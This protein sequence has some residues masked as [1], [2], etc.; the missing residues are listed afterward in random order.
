MNLFP[1]DCKSAVSRY[2]TEEVYEQLK[3]LKTKRGVTLL[4]IINSGVVNLDSSNGVYLGD[5]E[6]YTLF[7]PLINPIIEEYQTPYKVTDTHPADFDPEHLVAPNPDPEGEFILSTRVRVARNLHGYGLTP[8]LTKEERVEIERRVV[9][10][11][12]SLGGELAGHYYPLTGMTSEVQQ[13]L[14]DDHFLFKKGDRFL[15][16]AGINREWPEGR[17][18]FHNNDK[19]FLV[20]INEEDCLRI[21]SMQQGGDIEAVFRRLAIAVNTLNDKLKFQFHPN[22]G[23]L[24]SCPTNLGTG[25]RASVH[26]KIPHAIKHPKYQETLDKYFIQARGIHGEHSESEGGVYDISNRRRLGLSEVQCV[27]DMY[28]GVKALIDMEKELAAATQS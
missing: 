26:I 27:Q 15:E 22:L 17:G 20:W 4:D 28:H 1:K 2:L 3:D 23:F 11:L 25:M 5:E 14:I 18:I 16:A 21:I 19:T 8:S 12:Q 24:S 13:Q 10:V 7:A 9:E 6:S